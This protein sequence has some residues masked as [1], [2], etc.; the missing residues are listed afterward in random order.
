M[1]I[2]NFLNVSFLLGVAV[3]VCTACEKQN[4]VKEVPANSI[5]YYAK[6]TLEAKQMT[7]KCLAFNNNELSTMSPSK[8]K[9]WSETSAGINCHNAREAYAV[10]IHNAYNRKIN[11]TN[12]KY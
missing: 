7:E 12:D 8:Q 11:E 3:L 6:N 5:A 10:E 1:K 9:E 4:E 2:I